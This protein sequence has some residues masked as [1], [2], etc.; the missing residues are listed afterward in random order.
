MDELTFTPIK[1]DPKLITM[2]WA[3]C[4]SYYYMDKTYS[5]WEKQI[6]AQKEANKT[7]VQ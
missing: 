6:K 2:S 7:P 4:N 5:H 1:I 3:E